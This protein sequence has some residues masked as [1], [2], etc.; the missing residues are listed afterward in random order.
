ME[1]Q[2][3]VGHVGTM[4][5]ENENI[6]AAINAPLGKAAAD[7]GHIELLSE[8]IRLKFSESELA[9]LKR[10]YVTDIPVAQT[11]KPQIQD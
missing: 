2:P 1:C 7:R 11:K 8:A 4:D 6:G 10:L 9:E 5:I 3:A